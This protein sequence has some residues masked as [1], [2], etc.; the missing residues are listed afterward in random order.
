[1]RH[2]RNPPTRRALLRRLMILL[3]ACACL[4]ATAGAQT[5]PY[6]RW[7]NG[8]SEAWWFSETASKEEIKSMQSR[9]QLMA[10]ENRDA[11]SAWAG[12]YFVG[13]ETHGSYLR[14]APRGGFVLL[15]VNK[16]AAQVED[17]S[18]G[19]ASISATQIQLIPERMLRPHDPNAHSH[20]S[21][22]A[23]QDF[24]PVTFRGD[25]LLIAKREMPDFGDYIAGLGRFNEHSFIYAFDFSPFFFRMRE[26]ERAADAADTADAP[27]V[28][29][30]YERFLKRP[31]TGRIVSVG[32][33]TVRSGYEYKFPSGGSEWYDL[34]SVTRVTVNVGTT[35]GAEAGLQL[36][37]VDS[38]ETVKLTRVGKTSSTGIIIRS[39]DESRRETYYDHDA[40]REVVYPPVAAGREL[41]TTPF[42]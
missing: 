40:G 42:R 34:A 31:I 41:T 38:D 13:G 10:E 32:G 28:P 26:G 24:V 35:H 11:A 14:L 16:C 36:K 4:A 7:E 20:G 30:G 22:H 25:R 33:R 9:W 37:V 8:I 3:C 1:M 21:Q 39:L 6:E 27:V 12:D 15:K 23:D 17:F 18:Y 5:E 19:K 29:P 2:T